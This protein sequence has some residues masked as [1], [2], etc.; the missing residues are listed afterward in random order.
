MTLWH[1]LDEVPADLGRTAVVIG[2]FDGVHRGHQHVLATARARADT[3]GLTLV[4]VTFAPHPMAVLRPEHAPTTLTSLEHRAELLVHYGADAVL[5]LPFDREMASWSADDFAQRVLVDALHA[6]YVVVGANFRYGQ[7]ASG[8][9][10]C[11][12]DFGAGHDFEVTAVPLDGGPQVWSSTYVRTC[13]AAGD[14]AGAAEALGRPYAVRGVVVQGDQRGRELGFPT[15]NVPTEALDAVPPDGVYAGWLT[16]LDTGERFPA[17]ISVGTN[18]TFEGVVGRR[19][20]SYVLDRTDLELYGVEVQVEFVDH[21]RGQVAYT[22]V[23]PL[24]E[25]ITA[26]V[27]DTRRVLEL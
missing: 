14:V 26:D 15:A 8:D 12:A 18:P 3:D 21:L 23:D 7:K 11:L 19:V 9:V 22:G 5:A 4:A 25:Q 1:A 20:E 13:I 10:G 6:A 17:A 24:I 16:R 27:E 2:N